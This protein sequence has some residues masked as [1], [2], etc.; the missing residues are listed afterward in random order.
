MAYVRIRGFLDGFACSIA[1]RVLPW[2]RGMRLQP[3]PAR[4]GERCDD[5]EAMAKKFYLCRLRRRLTFPKIARS[6]MTRNAPTQIGGQS[7][8]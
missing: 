7:G 8:S 6:I 5:P 3:M 4:K 2:A 1:G